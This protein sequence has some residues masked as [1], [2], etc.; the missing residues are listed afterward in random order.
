MNLLQ[1]KKLELQDGI[2]DTNQLKNGANRYRHHLVG[3]RS[4]I[5]KQIRIQTAKYAPSRKK[6]TQTE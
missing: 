3:H 5:E 2:V 4:E 6:I 1:R